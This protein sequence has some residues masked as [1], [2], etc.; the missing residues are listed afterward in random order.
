LSDRF[1]WFFRQLVSES[2]MDGADSALEGA[3]RNF[4]VDFEFGVGTLGSEYG[5]ITTSGLD[6]V[7]AIVGATQPVATGVRVYAGVAYDSSGRRVPHS[8]VSYSTIDARRAGS[9]TIG[10]T[11]LML[12]PDGP[13]IQ[14]LAGFERWLSIFI[15]SGRLLDDPRIDGAG[16]PVY[17]EEGESFQ[18]YVKAGALYALSGAPAIPD[19]PLESGK[20]LL[21]DLKITNT[22]GDLEYQTPDVQRRQDWLRATS[23]ATFPYFTLVAGNP[24]FA[25]REVLRYLN[26]HV[27][28]LAGR[29][30]ASTID[31]EG[32]S[33]WIDGTTNPATS[34][35]GQ[36]DKIIEDLKKQTA[37]TSGA[38]K[39]GAAAVA[40]A[41]LSLIA[42]SPATQIAAIVARYNNHIGG[43]ADLH[44]A[45]DIVYAG[46]APNAFADASTLPGATSLEVI[47]DSLVQL[48]GST[49][50]GNAG[51][52]KVGGSVLAGSLNALTALTD[53]AAGR[54]LTQLVALQ[55]GVNGRVRR[56]GDTMVGGLGITPTDAAAIALRL[57][58]FS[59]QQSKA[60]AEYYSFDLVGPAAEIASHGH[61][62]ARSHQWR[63]EF[64]CLAIADLDRN[65][66][67]IAGGTGTIAMGVAVPGH[68]GGVVVLNCAAGA[69]NATLYRP[70]LYSLDETSRPRFHL[71]FRARRTVKDV[72]SFE[73]IGFGDALLPGT[74]SYARIFLNNG[75]WKGQVQNGVGGIETGEFGD[76][77]EW[78]VFEIILRSAS[79]ASFYM[80]GALM[81]TL[82][83]GLPAANCMLLIEHYAG[84]ANPGSSLLVDWIETFSDRQTGTL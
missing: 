9:T 2:E 33:P 46:S 29:Q 54:L 23:V 80:D 16:D 59:D 45:N 49:T 21:A 48:L 66:N 7:V 28:G 24:R 62:L 79:R 37:G 63:D 73:Q 5:G 61:Y 77:D 17:Y 40:G 13:D 65:W 74:A 64:M 20:V 84:V 39:I 38:H 75:G 56:G 69:G 32:G 57:S 44:P 47:I 15:V 43:G 70:A 55:T 41:P 27:A 82:N 81:G 34:V 4:A 35:E 6:L 78:H 11:G 12:L 3:D 60:L 25:I 36:L 26:Q 50:L 19:P 68:Y 67:R 76:N 42:S 1:N 10:E 52:D 53:L 58:P 51:T 18:F 30:L 83:T 8:P 71:A 31:Y 72:A 22:G 14:P